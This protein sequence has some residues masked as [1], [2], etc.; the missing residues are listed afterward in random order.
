MAFD[1]VFSDIVVVTPDVLMV[2]L[3]FGLFFPVFVSH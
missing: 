1:Y 2:V 3:I